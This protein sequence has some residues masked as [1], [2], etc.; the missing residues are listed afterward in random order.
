MH[1]P[2]RRRP[3]APRAAR[4]AALV[5]TL[6]IAGCATGAAPA[7]RATSIATSVS[8][9]RAV[10][11][12]PAPPVR[13]ISFAALAALPVLPADARMPYGDAAPQFGE[14]RLPPGDGPAPVVVLVHGGCW[15]AQ[16]DLRHL[17]QAAAALTAAGYAT[18]TL[19]YRR[20]GD[21]GG[22]W[23]GTFVDVARGIDHL[24]VVARTV[25]R[26]DTTRIVAVGHSAGGQLALWAAS[27]RRGEP[28]MAGMADT[29]PLRVHGAVSLAGITDLARFDAPS[30]CGSA[31]APLLGDD[32]AQR[33]ERLAMVSPVLRLPIGAR[34]G[35]VHA[36]DDAI[37]PLAQLE[38]LTTGARRVGERVLATVVPDAGHF[39]L[40]AP[41]SAAWPEVVRT[42]RALTPP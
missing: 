32:G 31:V 21:E 26:L 33:A 30:G 4:I 20:V 42:I 3:R 15:R 35:A 40:V 29:L 10:A 6:A 12:A 8:A 27:R 36:A 13:R 18:W 24:R 41:A 19:E 14:L 1:A 11:D 25:P 22:G 7:A 17:S 2:A 39:D 38:A 34:V 23:P 5:A 37:V 28:T 9:P 16:Y